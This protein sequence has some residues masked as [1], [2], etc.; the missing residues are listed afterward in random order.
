MS[1]TVYNSPSY[2]RSLRYRAH[3]H[4]SPELNHQPLFRLLRQ[5]A[6]IRDLQNQEPLL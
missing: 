1:A 2:L 5:K 3:S 4:N 6:E